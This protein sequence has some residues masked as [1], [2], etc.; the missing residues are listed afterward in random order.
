MKNYISIYCIFIFGLIFSA[1]SKKGTHHDVEANVF[2]TKI[3]DSLPC[4]A[5]ISYSDFTADGAIE[6]QISGNWQIQRYLHYDQ[7][8]TLTATA[9]TN[10]KTLT[11]EIRAKSA[12]VSDSCSGT[13]CTVSVRKDLYD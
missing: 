3:V 7:Y 10:I 12:P 5:N 8:V 9:H 11:V 4:Q 2:V 13:T 6:E 1:C